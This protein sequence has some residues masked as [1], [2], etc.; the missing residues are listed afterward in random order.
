MVSSRLSRRLLRHHLPLALLSLV[1]GY[2]LYVT[3][4]YAQV[5]PRLS[6]ASAYPALLLLCLTLLLGPWKLLA[7][8]RLAASFDLR[9]DIGIWAGITGLFHTVTGQFVHMGGRFWLYYVY[10]NW[11]TG[12]LQP[13]RHD[14]FGFDNDTGLI[15]ALI[16][17]A[18]LATSNDASLRWL[19]TPGWKSLQRW[20]YACFALAAAHTFGYQSGGGRGWFLVL[21]VTAVA[22]TC[23]LQRIG[24]QR[25]RSANKNGDGGF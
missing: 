7:G 11:R 23:G 12:H 18:L 24:W 5:I 4:S 16:L 3:R 20:N 2:G 14:L 10:E 1:S 9:R 22:I 17:L 21:S 8:V 13:F 15:A 25:R 6:F 19:G